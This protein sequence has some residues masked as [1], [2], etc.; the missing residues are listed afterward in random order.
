MERCKICN[1]IAKVTLPVEDESYCE[2]HYEQLPADKEEPKD[3]EK[4]DVYRLL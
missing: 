1:V 2:R 4:D 3:K